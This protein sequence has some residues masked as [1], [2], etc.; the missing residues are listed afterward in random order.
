MVP[1]DKVSI[2]TQLHGYLKGIYRK[3]AW[4]FLKAKLDR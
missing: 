3:P 1:S 4:P 2:S